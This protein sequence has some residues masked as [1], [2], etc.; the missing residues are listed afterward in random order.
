MGDNTP[1]N[2]DCTYAEIAAGLHDSKV[3]FSEPMANHTSF[4]IGGPCDLLV[5][6]KTRD[7]VIKAWST[8][9]N[10]GVPCYIAG[11]CTN[12]L[13]KDGGLRGCMIKLSPGFSGIDRR[14]GNTLSVLAGS[15]LGQ[16]VELSASLGLAGLEFAAGI[17]GSIG[18]AVTMNAGAY[19]S[20]IS[21]LVRRVE[22]ATLDGDIGF[23][24]ASAL[25]FSYRHSFFSGR[26]D[27][28]ILSADLVLAQGDT[29]TI[30]QTVAQ[31]LKDRQDK[32]PLDFPSAGS[33]FKRPQGRYVGQMIEMLGLKGLSCGG[34]MISPKH[35]GFIVNTGKATAEDVLTLMGMIEKKV[36]EEFGVRLE[37]EI[38]VIG[39]D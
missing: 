31:R 20:D 7:D 39:E 28:L 36:Y 33:V 13:V 34:A 35:A 18:G 22:V 5:V 23:V 21:S 11:N 14:D 2:M 29:G 10:L 30:R 4:R 27:L 9:R 8:C 12:L 19:G 24:S 26:E 37:P 32:Q 15:L 38:V 1:R 16:V 3:F 25:D 17:P 6:P